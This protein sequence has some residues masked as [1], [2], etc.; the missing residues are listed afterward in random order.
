MMNNAS[1]HK[2]KSNETPVAYTASAGNSTVAPVGITVVRVYT[3][4]AA[5]IAIGKNAVATVNDAPISAGEKEYF[6]IGEGE[7]V[8]AIQST[9]AGNLHVSFMTQ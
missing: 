9:A 2:I 3:T 6:K 4:T 5:F 7:R 1:V 8:S